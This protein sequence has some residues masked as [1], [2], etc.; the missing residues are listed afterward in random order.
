MKPE[1]AEEFADRAMV[2]REAKTVQ[3]AFTSGVTCSQCRQKATVK[4]RGVW[5]CELDADIARQ[6]EQRARMRGR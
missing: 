5:F 2:Q 1:R 4:H 6:R 3:A